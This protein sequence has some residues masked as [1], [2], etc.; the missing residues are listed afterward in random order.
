MK[1][2]SLQQL[3]EASDKLVEENRLREL[4][5]VFACQN[6][7]Y[8]AEKGNQVLVAELSSPVLALAHNAGVLYAG[9]EFGVVGIAGNKQ[10]SSRA[11]YALASHGGALYGGCGGI[12]GISR[13]LM[14]PTNQWGQ[15]YCVLNDYKTADIPGGVFALAS[16]DGRLYAS[17]RD[18]LYDGLTGKELRLT[19]HPFYIF[20]GKVSTM[21]RGYILGLA[22][23]KG[24]LYCTNFFAGV[25]PSGTVID[26]FN[27]KTIL[28]MDF[29]EFDNLTSVNDSLYYSSERRIY[30][31]FNTQC[32]VPSDSHVTAMTG[33]P[34]PLWKELAEKGRVVDK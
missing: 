27:K 33:I 23:H 16:H 3:I 24:L 8:C 10:V 29:A 1:A 7:V 26:V 34:M 2:A 9:G 4:G 13:G 25:D 30:D 20:Y 17:N 28:E 12:R 32:D 18:S 14:E 15:V 5:L 19:P 31:V 21:R 11:I 22:S 6:K